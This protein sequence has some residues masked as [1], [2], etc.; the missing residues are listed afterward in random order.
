MGRCRARQARMRQ[1]RRD[2][3]RS[4][5]GP[6]LRDAE[7][8]RGEG[9][10]L[11]RAPRYRC[12]PL[13][14]PRF[15]DVN[16]RRAGGRSGTCRRRGTPRRNSGPR[17]VPKAG[18]YHFAPPSAQH[19]DPSEQGLPKGALPQRR[20]RRKNPAPAPLTGHRA[21]PGR[22][23]RD[24]AGHG[25]AVTSA[26]G[27]SSELGD[28]LGTRIDASRNIRSLNPILRIEAL[29]CNFSVGLTGFE[30]ATP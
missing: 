9:S 21:R 29:T 23:S 22:R 27:H 12:E 15:R 18:L 5:R 13:E 4:E 17:V 3:E 16:E 30:P 20:A 24:A 11:V 1:R 2:E 8:R 10:P 14:R 7:R 25:P 19:R 26:I 28:R 6:Q